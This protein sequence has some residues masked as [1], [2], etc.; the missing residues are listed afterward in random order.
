M[1]TFFVLPYL[2]AITATA[3]S[4][5]AV[6]EIPTAASW[7]WFPEDVVTQGVRQTRYMRKTLVL[8]APIETARLRVRADDSYELRINGGPA[9]E[10]LRSGPGGDVYDLAGVLHPGKNVLAFSVYN[11]AGKGGLIVTGTVQG[12]NGK[13]IHVY[14]D[15]S[16]RKHNAPNYAPSP[17]ASRSCCTISFP[18]PRRSSREPNS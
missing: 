5:R 10:P 1:R 16:F 7:I 12:R 6:D 9:P 18:I 2:L 15:R 11:A 17:R 8:D 4:G 14:S 13:V 3:L